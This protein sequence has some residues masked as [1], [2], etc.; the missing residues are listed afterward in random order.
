M[1]DE[2]AREQAKNEQVQIIKREK[3]S[4]KSIHC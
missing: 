1:S 2:E 3:L 4:N